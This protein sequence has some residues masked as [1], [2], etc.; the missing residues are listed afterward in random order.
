MYN[1]IA[2]VF[3]LEVQR[4]PAPTSKFQGHTTL[5]LG[6]LVDRRSEIRRYALPL[7]GLAGSDQSMFS[8]DSVLGHAS[9]RNALRCASRPWAWVEQRAYPILIGKSE[10]HEKGLVIAILIVPGNSDATPPCLARSQILSETVRC[11]TACRATAI[12]NP[13]APAYCPHPPE[14]HDLQSCPEDG[15][16][17][18]SLAPRPKAWGL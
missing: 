6:G 7:N 4:F 13:W 1:M 5:R 12:M 9:P 15:L 2:R 16:Q 8:V 10:P 14:M 3:G 17:D 11:T 18:T